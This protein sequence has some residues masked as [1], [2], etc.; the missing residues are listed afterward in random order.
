[1]RAD[2]VTEVPTKSEQPTVQMDIHNEVMDDV[3]LENDD[4]KRTYNLFYMRIWTSQHQCEFNNQTIWRNLNR[5]GENEIKQAIEK[6][7]WHPEKEYMNRHRSKV[8]R[9]FMCV[10]KIYTS[11]GKIDKLKSRLV[12]GG[13]MQNR[14]LYPNVSSKT[15]VYQLFI[16]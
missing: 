11:Q 5:I 1:M 13:N 9:S 14:D 2:E 7:I 12:A 6:K 3:T 16:W 10:K 15:V 4:C 8:I